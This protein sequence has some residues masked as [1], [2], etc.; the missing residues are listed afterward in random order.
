MDTQVIFNEATGKYE[1]ARGTGTKDPVL[2][3]AG[4]A[5]LTNKTLTTPIISNPSLSSGS[6]SS[7]SITAG[8]LA[9][10]AGAVMVQEALFTQIAGNK[11]HTATFAISAGA[12]I[13]DVIVTNSVVWNSGTSATLIVGLTD[14]DCF[15]TG[16]DLK[17]VPAA[18]KSMRFAWPGASYAGASVPE[19]DG[20]AGDTQLGAT[21][22]MLYN[23][24]TVNLIAKVTDVNVSGTN[25]RTRVMVVYAYAT[26]TSTVTPVVT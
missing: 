17:T 24:A 1:F 16:G 13:I 3:E 6:I 25:G 18:G 10:M 2:T 23:A 4:T 8:S 12:T 22:G 11:T 7:A 19:I 26:D 15:F 5:T 20:G 9:T 21:G 14:D